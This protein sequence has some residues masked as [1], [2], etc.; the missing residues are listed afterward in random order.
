MPPI[1]ASNTTAEPMARGS[2]RLR[3]PSLSGAKGVPG[4]ISGSRSADRAAAASRS[5][6][7]LRVPDACEDI[8]C[9]TENPLSRQK[10]ENAS[11]GGM[12][13]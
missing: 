13:R 4:M 11:S 10:A 2:I 1:S 7:V 6:D 9:A 12:P 5:P 3:M 8:P